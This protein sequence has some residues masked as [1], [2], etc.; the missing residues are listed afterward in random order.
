MEM[1]TM[2][3]VIMQKMDNCIK[4]IKDYPDASTQ[5]QLFMKRKLRLF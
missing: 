3:K 5:E 1:E 2:L 4:D